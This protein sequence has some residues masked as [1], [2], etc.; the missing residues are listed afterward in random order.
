MGDSSK[1]RVAILGGDLAGILLLRGLLRYPHIVVDIY[2]SDSTFSKDGLAFDFPYTV[3]KALYA[4]DPSLN[5]CLDRAGAVTRYPPD[6]YRPNRI[7]GRPELLSQLTAD[8]PQHAVHLKAQVTSI[9]DDNGR[10]GVVLAFADGSQKRYDVLVGSDGNDG[11]SRKYVLGADNPNLQLKHTGF[12]SLHLQVPIERAQEAM[13][14]EFLDHYKP[15]QVRWVSDGV[16]MQHDLLNNGRDVQV[17]VYAQL[18]PTQLGPRCS[19]TSQLTPD[20]LKSSMALLTPEEFEELFSNLKSEACKGIVK[21]FRNIFT[22]Q[23][24]GPLERRDQFFASTP[25]SLRHATRNACLVGCAAREA[26]LS[27]YGSAAAATLAVEQAL[28]LT[29][30]LG[31]ADSKVKVP[32]ALRTY[33]R[34][35]G[36][37]SDYL[38]KNAFDTSQFLAGRGPFFTEL[39]ITR[40]AQ[41][42]HTA[43]LLSEKGFCEF[44]E[45]LEHE[46][47]A[48]RLF[49][50]ETRT[51]EAFGF[52][53]QLLA[54]QALG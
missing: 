43:V 45:T 4:I 49:V 14:T 2:D 54:E 24:I 5:Q 12:W 33:D 29:R 41:N 30:L 34:S 44:V 3:Q 15:K 28:A 13:G 11:L 35:W 40:Q 39:D 6:L 23:I 38:I 52:M 47:D 37:R 9:R 46:E 1:T 10:E 7:V 21:L 19:E 22:V 20:E 25:M 48:L 26:P 53:D 27:P 50:L 42:G 16:F 51:E 8:L 31:R 36:W 18:D 32:A 17:A